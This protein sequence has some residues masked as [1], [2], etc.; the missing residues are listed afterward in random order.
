MQLALALLAFV[1]TATAA[2]LKATPPLPPTPARNPSDPYYTAYHFQPLKNVRA[3]AFPQRLPHSRSS[4]SRLPLPLLPPPALLPLLPPS[5]LTRDVRVQW[6]NDRTPR[7]PSRRASRPALPLPQPLP[8][9]ASSLLLMSDTGRAAANGPFYDEATQLYHLFAQ[10]N[11]HG[12]K[13]GDMNWCALLRPSQ[14]CWPTSLTRISRTAGTMQCRRTWSTG[15]TCPSLSPRTMTTT[16]AASSPAPP[17]CCRTRRARPCFPSR[18][19][20]AS[21]CSSPSP[22]TKRPTVKW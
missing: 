14:S 9:D 13:W 8:L 11:P 1:A 17:P 3:P 21:G 16:A 15:R 22:R 10:Y 5:L 2:P 20:A 7:L 4:A 19:R 18:S 12:A 6:M